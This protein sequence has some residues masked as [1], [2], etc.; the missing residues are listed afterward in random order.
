MNSLY[1]KYIALFLI[2]TVS[3]FSLSGCYNIYNI[4]HLAYAVALGF[5]I[6]EDNKLKLSFQLSIP[7]GSSGCGGSS[8]QS[9]STIVNTIECSSIDSGINLLNSYLSKEVNLSHCKVIVFSEEFAY[10]GLSESLYSLM[11]NVQVR[12]DCNIIVSRCT[13]EYFL[14]NSQPTLEKLSA[15]YYEIAPTSSDYTGYTESVTLSEFFSNFNDTFAQCYA[16]LGGVNTG[17]SQKSDSTQSSSEKDSTNKANETQTKSKSNVEN[18][19]LAVFFADKLVGEL[20]GIDTVCHQIITNKLDTCN[21]IIPSLFEE[22]K[23]ITLRVRLS[24]NTKNNVELTDTGPYITSKV[25]LEA[26]ILSMDE[27]S[28]YLNDENIKELERYANS[29]MN[30]KIHTYLYKVSKEFNSDI[31][32]FGKYAVKN[33]LTWDDWINYNWLDNYKNSFFEV[34]VNTDVKSGYILM[35]T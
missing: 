2:L 5:D 13:A 20:T 32:G 27:N 33:F 18:M 8:S 30:N 35:E 34:N 14:N 10:N 7:G 6:G 9:D 25:Y 1:K 16:I 24:D 28:K 31:D 12:P 26:R 22:G 11:N 17:D 4:D 21:I 19:G 15:R 23:T 29:Y 3:L